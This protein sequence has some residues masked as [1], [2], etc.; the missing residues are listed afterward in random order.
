MLVPLLLTLVA[1]GFG[2]VLSGAPAN[3]AAI[4]SAKDGIDELLA[5]STQP[6][7]TVLQTKKQARQFIEDHDAFLFDCDGVLW[8]GE[9]GLLPGTIETLDLLEQHGKTCVFV[10]N[11]AAKSRAA[12]AK[13][14][15]GLGLER[16]TIDQVVPSSFVAARWLAKHQPHVKALSLIHI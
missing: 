2:L 12:Y 10:T 3:Q 11:N 4:Q 5:A 9:D 8:R 1:S 16:I 13:R 6:P 15:A 14:F 7:F